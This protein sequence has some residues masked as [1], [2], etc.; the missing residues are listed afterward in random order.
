MGSESVAVEK[1]PVTLESGGA[2][3]TYDGTPLTN[4]A[5]S[6]TPKGEGIG[7]VDGEGVAV[8]VTGSQTDVGESDNTFYFSFNE[9]T[10]GDD[11]LVTAKCGKLTDP[12]RNSHR[13]HVWR[14]E[15]LRRHGAHGFGEDLGLRE[16]RDRQ[17]RHHRQPDACGHERQLLCHHMGRHC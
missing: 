8:T 1:R 4:G 14:V 9:G 2:D 5:V 10:S 11:Y 16:R 6:V 15:A 17:L 12:A 3:K 7:F 13:Y